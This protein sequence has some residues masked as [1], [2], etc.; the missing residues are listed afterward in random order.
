M[1]GLG[2]GRRPSRKVRTLEACRKVGIHQVMRAANREGAAVCVL[3]WIGCGTDG[4]GVA[5]QFGNTLTVLADGHAHVAKIAFRRPHI[6]GVSASLI[7]GSCV[8]EA[9]ALFIVDGA[10]VCRRCG[11]LVYQS[12]LEGPVGRA[13][14]K[15]A[16]LIKRI[17]PEHTRDTII[18]PR[19]KGQW[20]RTYLRLLHQLAGLQDETGSA[21]KVALSKFRNL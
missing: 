14:I 10:L 3:T 18:P 2:S 13:R 5:V 16:R 6:G 1:G 15:E 17:D 4:M 12:Q 20:R 19:P 11:R 9:K 8:R 7:C 21:T